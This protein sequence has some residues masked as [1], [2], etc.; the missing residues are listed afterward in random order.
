MVL[1]QTRRDDQAAVP[2]GPSRLLGVLGV[3]L[4]G[5]VVRAVTPQGVEAAPYGCSGFSECPCCSGSQSC[6]GGTWAHYDDCPS[7]GQCWWNIIL[8]NMVYCCDWWSPQYGHPCVCAN[9]NP[10][11]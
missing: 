8:C 4:F 10:V 11:C 7:G 9:Y 5:L 3:A 2:F 6:E 1:E